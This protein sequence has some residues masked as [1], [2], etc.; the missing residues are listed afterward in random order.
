MGYSDKEAKEFANSTIE[1]W[2]A[3][4][5]TIGGVAIAQAGK[6]QITSAYERLSNL[7]PGAK[8]ATTMPINKSIPSTSMEA[9]S[10]N[11]SLGM[12]A[13]APASRFASIISEAGSF[14]SKIGA[15]VNY[16]SGISFL[17]LWTR[18]G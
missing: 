9:S 5:E 18:L 17:V 16:P 8:T 3:A 14:A 1:G 2:D 4:K 12:R 11:S 10:I 7:Q 15:G 13:E 6:G